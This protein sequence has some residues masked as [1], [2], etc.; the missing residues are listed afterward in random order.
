[1]KERSE[2]PDSKWLGLIKEWLLVPF[3]LWPLD[4]AGLARHICDTVERGQR[5]EPRLIFILEEIHP[6]PNP[7]AQAAVAEYERLVEQGQYEPLIR[8]PAK[9]AAEEKD[10][11]K[12][13]K[14]RQEWAGLKKLFDVAQYRDRKGIIRRRMVQERNFRPDWDL[15]CESEKDC[16][17]AAFDAFCH[18]WNL[19]GME[20]DTPLL[21]K[22]TVNPTAHGLMVFIPTYWS[23]DPRRDLNWAEINKLHKARGGLRQGPKMSEGR[24]ARHTQAQLAYQ[25]AQRAHDLGLRGAKR[26]EFIVK[27]ASLPPGTEPR[28]IRRLLKE[29]SELA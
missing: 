20:L 5:L 8:T 19:Y 6:L 21:L 27:S 10:L 4:M 24:L 15:R 29:G 2:H 28:T 14:L 1:M 16:F 23:F 9:Y 17:L 11:L 12:N 22:L 18:R 25:A 3:T 13:G 26:L 7:E